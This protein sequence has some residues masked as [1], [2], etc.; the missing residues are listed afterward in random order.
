MEALADKMSPKALR[1]SLSAFEKT[2]EGDSSNKRTRQL[3]DAYTE[4]MGRIRAQSAGLLELAEL[5]LSWIVCAK[6]PLT[7]LELKTAL[8]VEV[9][10]EF[11]DE[12]NFTDI[13]DMITACN[14]LVTHEEGSGTMRLVHYTAQEY[15]EREQRSWLPQAQIVLSTTCLTYL[16]FDLYPN[17]LP[18]VME[19]DKRLTKMSDGTFPLYKYAVRNWGHHVREAWEDVKDL[20][21]EFLA[22]KKQLQLARDCLSDLAFFWNRKFLRS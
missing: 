11:V 4:A 6:S 7:A 8:A 1:A 2:A 15:L 14:G 18:D 9:G 20:V 19:Y 12:E 3:D 22:R 5:V 21:L 10:E 13:E 17:G 16:Q